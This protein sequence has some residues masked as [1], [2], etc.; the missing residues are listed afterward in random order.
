MCKFLLSPLYLFFSYKACV[1][2]FIKTEPLAV[3][4]FCLLNMRTPNPLSTTIMLHSLGKIRVFAYLPILIAI[5]KIIFSISHAFDALI[6][7]LIE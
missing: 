1:K 6:H 3:K 7:N 2:L 5:H 4:R